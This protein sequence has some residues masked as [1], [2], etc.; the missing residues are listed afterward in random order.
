M[1]RPPFRCRFQ[2]PLACFPQF[3]SL[4][5]SDAA[6]RLGNAEFGKLG[7]S[8]S[9]SSPHA[10]LLFETS[11]NH[12]VELRWFL[13]QHWY[14]SYLFV[15]VSMISFKQNDSIFVD[16]PHN[17]SPI[18]ACRKQTH[19]LVVVSCEDRCKVK[20]RLRNTFF[21]D[22]WSGCKRFANHMF[23][24]PRKQNS[25]QTERQVAQ[26][27]HFGDPLKEQEFAWVA[28]RASMRKSGWGV[29]L[30]N[31]NT[32][33]L[34]H[35]MKLRKFKIRL[36]ECKSSLFFQSSKSNQKMRGTLEICT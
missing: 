36:I 17:I 27:N 24:F 7:N 25:C 19:C 20:K 21:E 22:D 6:A 31:N 34:K 3:W 15:L 1:R 8:L 13:K 18:S 30:D 14:Y 9:K 5:K 10:W 12:L 32:L 16:A 2:T 29:H 35:K 28:T 4:V 23:P 26:F 11:G 33:S